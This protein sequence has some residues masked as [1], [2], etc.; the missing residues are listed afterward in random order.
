VY[1]VHTKSTS[2]ASRAIF[3]VAE[4]FVTLCMK[5]HFYSRGRYR[6]M[7]GVDARNG[8]R[9]TSYAGCVHSA[10]NLHASLVGDRPTA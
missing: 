8:G 1:I 7:Q 2:S 3:A 5:M 10:F 4:L 6:K 9:R